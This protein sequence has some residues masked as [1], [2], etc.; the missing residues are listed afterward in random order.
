MDKKKL[1]K[2]KKYQHELENLGEFEH[3]VVDIL[4]HIIA[5]RLPE[6]SNH[7]RYKIISHAIR[8]R[9]LD[10]WLDTE[11]KYKS[12]NCKKVYYFSLEFLMGRILQ[13]SAINIDAEGMSS[14]L[15][16]M[17]G[18]DIE[19]IY[20]EE[21]DAGLGNGGLGRL[22]A[23]FLDSMATM[24]IPGYGFGIRYEYG[25]F[26]QKIIDGWQIE[27]K[28]KWLSQGYPWE[29]QRLDKAINIK[30]Y[31]EVESSTDSYGN[32]KAKW[33]NANNVT[34]IPYDI[35]IPGYKN[36]TVNLLTLW[37]ASSTDEFNFELF[38]MGDYEKA[39]KAKSY[40]ET[41][42]KV[43]YPNDSFYSGR[44][45]RLKQ[46]YFFVSASL[47]TIFTDFWKNNSS[48]SDFPN[49]IAIQLNDTH[50]TI[51]I[52]ELMRLLIDVIKIDWD[53]AWEISTKTFA[54]T[55]H[56]LLPEA[57]EKWSVEMLGR[58][59]PRHLEII[60]EINKRFLDSVREKY[61]NDDNKVINMSIIEE[62]EQKQVRMAYLAVIG[63]HS[64]NGVAK[65]HSELLKTNVLPDFF[66]LYPEKFNNKTNGITQRRWLKLS[67]PKLSDLISNTIGDDW[68]TELSKLKELKKYTNDEY[69]CKNWQSIKHENKI[70]LAA[71]LKKKFNFDINP[72]T[73]FDSQFKRMHEY[74][75]QL[76]KVFHV[77]Y[78]YFQLKDKVTSRNIEFTGRESQILN[79]EVARTVLIGGKAAPSYA[80]AKRIIKLINDV[81]NVI[82]NDSETNKYLSLYYIPNYGVSL[83]EKIIPATDLSE[84]ISTAGTEASGTGNMKFALNGALTVGTM[85]G[86]N[87]EILEEVGKDNMYIFGM[88][89]EEV[90]S[91][92]SSGYNPYYYYENNNRLKQVIDSI[93]SGFFSPEE[94]MR[95]QPI[96]NSLFNGDQ[97]M[98][99]ADFESYIDIQKEVD[100]GYRDIEE[101]TKKSILNVANIGYFSS[102]RTIAE[103]ANDIW[104][105]SPV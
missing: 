75:R 41:I 10:K 79:D 32:H 11:E 102:D 21:I 91:L 5:K 8:S 57:L 83:A 39:V 74:K 98:L 26:N 81:S 60:Y 37:S 99:L 35:L 68:I 105:V 69:F 46:Q 88:N 49:K 7:D 27:E 31:G 70:R 54:Y 73:M 52:P 6:C 85:D 24:K 94:P 3:E 50:P 38:N 29:I 47:Q 89:A 64:V 14:T 92:K 61:P 78:K 62:G 95:F 77:I 67:N 40:D 36:E 48:I 2:I 82:N 9:I 12:T 19:D 16:Q 42:T 22:A 97:Y 66:E 65:L 4:H 45:L 1:E 58:V 55:N 96:I 72:D 28:D 63:S 13:N 23:C 17:I 51:A 76:L 18:I 44:E 101:W 15:M 87:I 34:A 90:S 30:F 20:E 53:T 103:Y 59:L 104:G 86:A 25:M 56:T 43:L 84:Q 80:I 71:Y 100:N 93:Q 33:I